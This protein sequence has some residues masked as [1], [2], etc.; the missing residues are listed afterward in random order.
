MRDSGYAS[1]WGVMSPVLAKT[2]PRRPLIPLSHLTRSDPARTYRLMEVVRMRL[3]ERRYSVRTEQAYVFWI[4]RF[5]Q[6]HGRRHP[7]ELGEPAVRDYLSHLATVDRVAA[8]THNQALAAPT[9]LYY[10]VFKRPLERIHWVSPA[11]R[12]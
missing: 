7:K 9:F 8:S 2:S 5:V 3:R 6:H 10:A 4:R 1:R 12:S 11:R